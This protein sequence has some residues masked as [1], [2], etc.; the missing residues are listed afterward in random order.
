MTQAQAQELIAFLSS[1]ADE[2][3]ADAM[4]ACIAG[5]NRERYM[6]HGKSEGLNFAIG[7]IQHYAGLRV[8]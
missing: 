2:A 7:V 4:A 3:N 1:Q 8:G 6:R 5:N